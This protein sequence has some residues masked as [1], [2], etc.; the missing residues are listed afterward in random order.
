[1]EI[2]DIAIRRHG[3]PI[4]VQR[5]RLGN[6]NI[7]PIVID[8]AATQSNLAASLKRGLQLLDGVYNAIVNDRGINATASVY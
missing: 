2:R 6:N 5:H 4:K 7:H 3:E 8:D 1:M